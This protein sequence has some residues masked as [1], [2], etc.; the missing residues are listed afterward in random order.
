MGGG[1]SS[2]PT[3]TAVNGANVFNPAPATGF[4]SQNGVNAQW[5]NG[6]QPSTNQFGGNQQW[7]VAPAAPPN[8]WATSAAT[9]VK[10]NPVNPFLVSFPTS[11]DIYCGIVSS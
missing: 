2:F 8:Q 7:G 4:Q 5:G 1:F 10:P 3:Q 6:M 11:Y 9:T